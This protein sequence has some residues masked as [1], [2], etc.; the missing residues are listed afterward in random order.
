MM[1][2][3]VLDRKQAFLDYQNIDFTLVTELDFCKG[4]S[5]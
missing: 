1:F 5:P 2:S 3:Y 4:V